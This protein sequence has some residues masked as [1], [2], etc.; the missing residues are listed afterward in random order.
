M[1]TIGGEDDTRSG[2]ARKHGAWLA[3]KWCNDGFAQRAR[4]L[5]QQAVV[6]T[7]AAVRERSDDLR[8]DCR[9]RV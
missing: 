6:V 8:A 4:R 7:C 9:R 5:E 2:F 1:T 3:D